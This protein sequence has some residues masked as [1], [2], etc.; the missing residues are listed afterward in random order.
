MKK[1]SFIILSFVIFFA[2][3]CTGDRDRSRTGDDRVMAG[4]DNQQNRDRDFVREAASAGM[5]EVELGR[6]AQQNAQNQRVRNFAQMIVRDHS[7]AND[8]L[9]A[10]AQRKNFTIP[11]TME[12]NHQN[13]LDRFRDK[14]G[15]EFDKDY[16]KEM[17]DEHEDDVDRFKKYAEEGN[18]PDLKEFARKTLSVLLMHQD[19]AKNIH[20]A[21]K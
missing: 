16:M 15:S 11:G 2:M 20:D 1:L 17:V 18:D 10:I 8:E 21:I 9:R 12:N 4:S 3:S 5:L 14:K 19:S 6:Y 13:K 7:Q